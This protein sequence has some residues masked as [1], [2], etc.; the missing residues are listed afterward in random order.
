[1]RP[2]GKVR[3]PVV[4]I[5][6]S[7][8]TLGI[9]FVWWQYQTLKELRGYSGTG[10]GEWLGLAYAVLSL[11]VVNLVIIPMEVAKLYESLNV[12]PPVT[13]TT[14]LWNLI[15]GIGTLIWLAK[16]QTALNRYWVEVGLDE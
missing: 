3:S 6:A 10:I 9:Y 14:A 8:L 2:R 5:V 16:N 11:G 13:A 7:L 1:V 4:V 15:P 12:D